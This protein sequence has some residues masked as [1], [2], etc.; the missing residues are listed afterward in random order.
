MTR[1]KKC[2]SSLTPLSH[3]FD[4]ILLGYTPH[5]ISYRVYNLETNTI[6][7]SCD[8]TFDDTAPYP[9]DV[10]ECAGDKKMEGNTFVDERLQGVDGGEDE[11][12]LRSTSSSEYV[13]AFTLKAEASQDTTS[14]TS[15]VE[16]S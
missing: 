15:A 8:V 9:C 7:E 10:F 16:A 3:S 1:N 13:S 2:F 12:L 14:S 5:D 6:I 4:G 11:L